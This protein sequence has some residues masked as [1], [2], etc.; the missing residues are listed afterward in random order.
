MLNLIIYRFKMSLYKNNAGNWLL[1][2]YEIC[3]IDSP[4]LEFF[5]P[6]WGLTM[7]IHEA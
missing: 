6:S 5:K 4:F 3:V 1:K 7:E 2:E